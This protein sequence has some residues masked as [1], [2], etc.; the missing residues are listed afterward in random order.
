MNKD[1]VEKEKA[2][3]W[4]AQVGGELGGDPAAV[5]DPGEPAAKKRKSGKLPKTMNLENTKP[6]IPPGG[7]PLFEDV[8]E[9][10]IRA[11]YRTKKGGRPSHGIKFKDKADVHEICK[12][13]LIWLWGQHEKDGGRPMPFTFP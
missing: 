7:N 8:D 1:I 4:P 2:E 11:F 9:Q 5:P 12:S 13:L 3:Q 10:R 6:F